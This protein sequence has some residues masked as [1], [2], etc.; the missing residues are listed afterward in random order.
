MKNSGNTKLV[1]VKKVNTNKIK[2]IISL[3]IFKFKKLVNN[4]IFLEV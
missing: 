4:F 3:I 1:Y 2:L